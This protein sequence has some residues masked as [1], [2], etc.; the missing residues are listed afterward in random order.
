MKISP[1]IKDWQPPVTYCTASVLVASAQCERYGLVAGYFNPQGGTV[2]TE[3]GSALGEACALVAEYWEQG[4]DVYMI[5]AF[6]ACLKF[7]VTYADANK[8]WR[9]LWRAVLM[10]IELWKHQFKL[11]W[12]FHTAEVARRINVAYTDNGEP[13]EYHMAGS[14]D[15]TLHNMETGQYKIVDLKAVKT[16]YFYTWNH[17]IQVLVYNVLDDASSDSV[18]NYDRPEYWVYETEGTPESTDQFTVHV[19]EGSVI[20]TLLRSLPAQA[21]RQCIIAE[22]LRSLGTS[23]DS[24][25]VIQD[26]IDTLPANHKMCLRGTFKCFNY[27]LCHGE[28]VVRPGSRD[29]YD[30]PVTF[31]MD[32]DDITVLVEDLTSRITDGYARISYHD[33]TDVGFA[34][35]VDD[36]EL[37]DA[38]LKGSLPYQTSKLFEG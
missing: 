34:V 10:F 17:D 9:G 14:Q 37:T 19:L 6:E 15:L 30:A 2:H 26:T 7:P 3:F 4:Y 8:N 12:R 32:E 1:E 11:G 16:S 31:N 21:K 13:A 28:A 20:K 5:K 22:K 35:T 33:S 29:V 27:E 23:L 25:P 38:M 24:I 36:A 18:R